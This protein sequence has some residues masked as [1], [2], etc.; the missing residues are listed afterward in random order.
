MDG[1]SFEVFDFPAASFGM[2]ATVALNLASRVRPQQM[3]P[4][5]TT[6]SNHVRNP[7]TKANKPGATPK[8]I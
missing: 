4:V 2:R 6:V 7:I 1:K 3:K 5:S 8:D